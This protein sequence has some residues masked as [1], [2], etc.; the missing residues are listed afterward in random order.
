M[1]VVNSKVDDSVI[2]IVDASCDSTSKVMTAKVASSATPP[3]RGW[4]RNVTMSISGSPGIKS[5]C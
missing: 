5:M 3:N 2:S 1:P 4:L